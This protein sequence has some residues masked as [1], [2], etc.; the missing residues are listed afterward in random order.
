MVEYR[1]KNIQQNT[2]TQNQ[3]L[4]ENLKELNRQVGNLPGAIAGQV[5]GDGNIN[6]N[7]PSGITT[8]FPFSIPFSFS[9]AVMGLRAP[10]Q[11]PRFEADFSGTIF[12]TRTLTQEYGM[13]GK[14]E[15]FVWVLDMADFESVAAVI[16]W[17]VWI[18]FFIG[19][20]FVTNKVIR[21]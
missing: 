17:T 7:T 9:R 3:S 18:S 8:V 21:W 16:R 4:D 2:A 6:F 14:G 12:D 1:L 5:V 19:L 10:P 11:A 20:M 13:D 15:N